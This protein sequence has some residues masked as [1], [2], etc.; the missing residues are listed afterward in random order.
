MIPVSIAMQA[1]GSYKDM[2]NIDF[3]GLSKKGLFLISGDTGS[4]KTTILDAISVAL[5]CRSTGGLRTF[6]ELRNTE[7]TDDKDTIVEY[8]FLLGV[9]TY[10]FRRK[11]KMHTIRGRNKKELRDEHECF[12]FENNE[13]KLIESGSESKVRLKAQSIIGLDCDQ[14]SKVIVLP[15]GEFK[16]LI[17]SSS[18]EKEKVF[19]KLFK[20]ENYSRI[21]LKL[22]EECDLLEKR[23]SN[24]LSLQETILKREEVKDL[25]E[26]RL[27]F[28]QRKNILE[29]KLLKRRINDKTVETMRAKL[30]KLR[31]IKRIASELNNKKVE[32]ENAL[33]SLEKAKKEYK[34]SLKDEEEIE[35]LKEEEQFYISK[36]VM[37]KDKLEKYKKLELLRKSISEALE[38]NNL[39][40]N[41]V[42]EL[43][44]QYNLLNEDIKRA[45]NEINNFK[46][47]VLKIPE[48]YLDIQVLKEKESVY[49]DFVEAKK[50]L[51][52]A[53]G[54]FIE[55]ERTYKQENIT[56]ESLKSYREELERKLLECEY[57]KMS[58]LLE[59]GKPCP[60]CGSVEHPR[61]AIFENGNL[62]DILSKKENVENLIS[63]QVEVVNKIRE[64]FSYKLAKLDNI[65][66]I[67][68][69]KRRLCS[70]LNLDFASL[71]DNISAKSKELVKAKETQNRIRELELF[72]ESKK[73]SLEKLDEEI[74]KSERYKESAKQKILE[75]SLRK[76]IL[77]KEIGKVDNSGVNFEREILLYNEKIKFCS[78]EAKRL[79]DN[80]NNLKSNLEK[81]LLNYKILKKTCE[82]LEKNLLALNNELNINNL[83]DIKL[84]E[85]ELEELEKEGKNL[86]E[87]I[88][89]LSQTCDSLSEYIRELEGLYVESEDLVSKYSNFKRLYE[90]LSGTN[91]LKMPIKMFVLGIMLDDIVS[92]ANVYLAKFSYN[93]Y[94]LSRVRAEEILGR[95]YN[96]LDLEVFDAYNGTVRAVDT[97]SG[98]EIFLASLSLAFG[99]SD[100]IQSYA[101]G[102]KINSIFIDEGFGSL[103][104]QT[105]NTAIDA[106]CEVIKNGRIVGII[107]HVEELKSRIGSKIE[108]KRLKAKGGNGIEV[109]VVLE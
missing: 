29:E 31:D 43:R 54:E 2:V 11:L 87:E 86:Q 109:N 42:Q 83:T 75:L 35:R 92:H 70:S 73:S 4:G 37:V 58:K 69:S 12:I 34:D 95:G 106:F 53:K 94:S 81:E 14:F 28:L 100:V 90:C 55:A 20:T 30:L 89:R 40:T 80:T 39:D 10:K 102:I 21:T 9:S 74:S 85:T 79:Q 50:S 66:E 98:G 15:Q 78:D 56:L 108:I 105:L 18:S 64:E 63:K 101:G 17:L 60:I 1:F 8:V 36:R 32:T 84:V 24:V 38:M 3:E 88:G 16:N 107:S 82:G 33:C 99:L 5:Y 44:G 57:F 91:K 7:A 51:G 72:I 103:D 76:D 49:D 65:R 68:E 67:Y 19:T 47:I 77:I 96:G 59:K 25:E 52:E 48:L 71:K 104:F 27:K 45:M 46:S 23:L 97:L 22:R 62:E 26:L 61:P 41:R 93:R 13:W 6:K